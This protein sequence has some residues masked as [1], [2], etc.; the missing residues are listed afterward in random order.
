MIAP[1]VRRQP[2]RRGSIA[3]AGVR[4]CE[5]ESLRQGILG[6]RGRDGRQA[7]G[8]DV[9]VGWTP[10]G[11]GGGGGGRGGGGAGE[12]VVEMGGMVVGECATRGGW[13]SKIVNAD[14]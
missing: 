4:D 5:R 14:S 9:S 6:T 2:P 13:V 11:G 10:G 8:G 1:G 7:K 12:G 3:V